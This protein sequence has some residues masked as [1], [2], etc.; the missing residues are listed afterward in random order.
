MALMA[1]IGCD[2]ARERSDSLAPGPQEASPAGPWT[3]LFLRDHPLVGRI[4]A[5]D[6]SRFVEPETV[7]DA[8]TQARYVMLGET[9]DNPDHHRLQAWVVQQMIER[10]R[11][12]AVA[13]EMIT[14]DE[15]PALAAQL[16]KDSRHAGP[17]GAV[18]RWD[19]RGW[20]DW[21]QYR[22]IAQAALDKGL[23]IVAA[24]LGRKTVRALGEKGS[25]ALAPS[26]VAR[27]DL[28]RPLEPRLQKTVIAEM[29]RDHCGMLSDDMA[30][31]MVLILRARDGFMADRLIAAA[32]DPRTDG[33]VLISGGGHARRD[34]GVPWQLARLAPSE[35][36][37]SIAFIQVDKTQL[38]PAH[39]AGQLGAVSLPFDFVWFT[40]RVDLEDP[41]EKHREELQRFNRR[42]AVK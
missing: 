17:I 16:V 6:E 25:S 8:A 1:L 15:A 31:R 3:S 37:V 32:K 10:G 5:V 39:Y 11:R 36:S 27:I 29:K 20:S 23:P 33:A 30:R 19:E 7:L 12:P 41:C 28:D 34:R 35:R 40:P 21:Q 2:R 14:L 9:H 26:L 13:F 24:D 22:P 18:V 42:R 4:W 38:D